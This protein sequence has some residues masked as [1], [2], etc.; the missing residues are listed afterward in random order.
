M[1]SARIIHIQYY[2][3]VLPPDGGPPIPSHVFGSGSKIVN[4]NLEFFNNLKEFVKIQFLA[5]FVV[6]DQNFN[7]NL[8]NYNFQLKETAGDL[9]LVSWVSTGYL[10]GIF[11]VTPGYLLGFSWVYLGFLLGFSWVSLGYLLGISW[12][13]LE[14]TPCWGILYDNTSHVLIILGTLTFMGHKNAY[15]TWET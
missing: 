5:I 8:N 9:L 11:W 10:L 12:D 7:F 1:P 14:N 6:P 15:A 4:G 3:R 13:C 2:E